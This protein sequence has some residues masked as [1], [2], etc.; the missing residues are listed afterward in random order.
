M[1]CER[2][3]ASSRPKVRPFTSPKAARVTPGSRLVTKLAR[4]DRPA[5]RVGSARLRGLSYD[6]RGYNLPAMADGAGDVAGACAS[7]PLHGRKGGPDSC[8][9]T[10]STP[11]GQGERPHFPKS[12]SGKSL[13]CS[14]GNLF[15]A[16]CLFR[17]Q[18]P[19]PGTSCAHVILV[20][21]GMPTASTGG[22]SIV[23]L[24]ERSRDAAMP[25]EAARL[26]RFR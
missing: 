2:P 15:F 16:P 1:V 20:A 6:R 14:A 9:A 23:T 3:I 25:P 24:S 5:H 17:R 8:G 4:R 13:R 21:S 11:C 7:R 22:F 26:D 10:A 12:V 18:T 19:I